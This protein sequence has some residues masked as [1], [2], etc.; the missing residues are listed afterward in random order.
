MQAMHRSKWLLLL[1][2]M[3]LNA[4]STKGEGGLVEQG[5]EHCGLCFF[6]FE[7]CRLHYVHRVSFS[8]AFLVLRC[9]AFSNFPLSVTVPVC[10]CVAG[11]GCVCSVA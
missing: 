8:A 11:H 7:F 2:S 9:A 4:V 10:V 6:N 5:G 1:L 3:L